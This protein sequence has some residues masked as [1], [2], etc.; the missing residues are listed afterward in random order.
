ML[1]KLKTKVNKIG[2]VS[3]SSGILGEDFVKHQLKIGEERLNKYGIEVEYLPNALKGL[4]YLRN[5][6][7]KR[8][9]DLLITFED[10][11]IDMIL[12]AIGGN[13][14]YRLLP[15]LLEKDHLEELVKQKIFLGFSDTTINHFML[16]KLGIQTFYGQAYLTDICELENEM[17]SYTKDYFEELI[18]TGKISELTPSDFWCEERVDFSRKEIGISRK[19]HQNSSWELINGEEVFEGEILGGCLETIYQIFDNTRNKD[20]VKICKKYKIFPS[21]DE[22][23]DKILF[24]ET[25]ESKSEPY[26]FE[27]MLS[28]LKDYG[29]FNVISGLLVGKPQDESY[30]KEYKEILLEVISDKKLPILYN[31]NIGHALPRGI[32][33]FGIPAKVNGTKQKITFNY[34]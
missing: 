7:E 3:L 12:C 28:T 22:W 30:Y 15:Y 23:K 1:D 17:L 10:D 21:L 26:F 5:H 27:K 13:D 8:A 11:S 33:P 32:I 16:Y 25:S 2:I 18:S 24:L 20:S 9:E 34:G 31:L 6:P 29:I 14:T 4:E 19:C